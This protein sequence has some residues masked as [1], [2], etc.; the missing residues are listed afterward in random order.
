MR[1]CPEQA[2]REEVL[3]SARVLVRKLA[4]SRRWFILGCAGGSSRRESITLAADSV[5]VFRI[6]RIVF[7]LLP[8]PGDMDINGP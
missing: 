3:D 4:M 7:E 1:W 5:N 2:D 8:Q 6:L